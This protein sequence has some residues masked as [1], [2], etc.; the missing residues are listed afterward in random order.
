MD[1]VFAK[2]ATQKDKAMDILHIR[3]GG[4]KIADSECQSLE[5][6]LTLLIR[7]LYV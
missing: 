1:L 5:R 6:S 2:I 7:S 4:E 3:E